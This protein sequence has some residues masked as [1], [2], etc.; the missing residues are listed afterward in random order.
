[1]YKNALPSS[2][3]TDC[4]H[5]KEELFNALRKL[6]AF[7][8]ANHSNAMLVFVTLQL[9]VR[10]GMFYIGLQRLDRSL[11]VRAGRYLTASK[12]T[13]WVAAWVGGF[14]SAKISCVWKYEC[15]K[16]LKKLSRYR[17]GGALGV[18]GGRG[19]RISRQSAHEGGKVVSPTHRPSLPQKHHMLKKC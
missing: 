7:R 19:S 5:Y 1:V 3:T 2:Q 10:T 18:P 13:E 8:C 14:R 12:N 6:I 11:E 16:A 17:P 4:V 9:A 15:R